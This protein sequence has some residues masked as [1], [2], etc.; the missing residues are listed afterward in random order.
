MRKRGAKSSAGSQEGA[1][2]ENVMAREG[3]SLMARRNHSNA[4]GEYMAQPCRQAGIT[5]YVQKGGEK[6]GRHPRSK[7]GE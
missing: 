1:G 3:L 7:A 4:H 5:F 6:R 2:V